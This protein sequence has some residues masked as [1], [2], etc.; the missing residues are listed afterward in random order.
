MHTFH[1]V[2]FN[3]HRLYLYTTRE[4]EFTIMFS[5]IIILH[6]SIAA[7][8]AQSTTHVSRFG[9]QWNQKPEAVWLFIF[10][11]PFTRCSTGPEPHLVVPYP[12]WT[13][14]A[15]MDC[16]HL[17]P[18]HGGVVV[19]HKNLTYFKC[20]SFF[21]FLLYFQNCQKNYRHELVVITASVLLR[22]AFDVIRLPV[23]G[24]YC[25]AER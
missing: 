1:S 14:A 19:W 20:M 23:S 13:D 21:F 22:R 10:L 3:V 7:A 25:A 2:C 15:V 8:K 24:V 18:A 17:S 16:R 9:E 5:I 11:S 4:I 6:F 12:P